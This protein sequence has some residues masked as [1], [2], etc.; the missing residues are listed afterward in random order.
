MHAERMA[1]QA[2]GAWSAHLR[3]ATGGGAVR[4]GREPRPGQVADTRA[5][6]GGRVHWDVVRLRVRVGPGTGA[7]STADASGT[8]PYR[9]ATELDRCIRTMGEGAAEE[10]RAEVLGEP[11]QP[12][13]TP[14][15]PPACTPTGLDRASY[16][17][18]PGTSTQDFGLTTLD[19]PVGVPAAH[20]SPVKGGVRFDQTAAIMAPLRSVFTKAGSFTE[21]KVHFLGGGD[22]PT[23]TMDARWTIRPDGATR[24]A[25]AEQEHCSD[26]ALA[27]DLSLPRYAQAVNDF[28]AANRVFRSHRA[29]V[30][31]VTAKTGVAPDKWASVFRCLACKTE[32]RDHIGWHKPRPFERKPDLRNNCADPEFIITAGSLPEVSKHPPAEIIKDCGETPGVPPSIG[33]Q[34]QK[35]MQRP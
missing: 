27:F 25:E 31:A 14:P 3:G 6:S 4:A 20:T 9:E 1:V 32:S 17:A 19:G 2:S 26:L 28:A 33:T 35:C 24:I 21:G 23:K 5:S 18:V 34:T 30:A 12:P 22:C 29:A 11:M 7:E 15:P 8:L 10:C 13:V 16:L